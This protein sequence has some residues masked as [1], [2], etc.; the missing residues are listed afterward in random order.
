MLYESVSLGAYVNIFPMQGNAS[1]S[2]EKSKLNEL[3]GANLKN[4][5]KKDQAVGKGTF[6]QFG[7][8]RM[9]RLP[10]AKFE[11]SHTSK[12]VTGM[13]NTLKKNLCID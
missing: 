1:L 6:L 7:T 12:R 9:Q 10:E 8:A 13:D 4:T 2:M 3:T 11:T 5:E